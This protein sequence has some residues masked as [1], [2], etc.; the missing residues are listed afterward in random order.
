[1]SGFLR[2]RSNR[3]N[4]PKRERS[5]PAPVP[6][7]HR[8]AA[9]M[10][11]PALLNTDPPAVQRQVLVVK[12]RRRTEAESRHLGRVKALRCVLC[13]ELGMTQQGTTEAHHIR[14]GQ[15]GAQRA[16]DWLA[17]ALCEDCHR[18][19]RGIHGDRSRLMQ[20]K[21]TELDLLAWTLRDL[22]KE[23]A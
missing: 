21:C 15:G 23:G 5:L 3:L 12:G 4:P 6:V 2:S 7:E 18:G 14:A 10:V 11:T 19:P 1:V 16:S 8:R 20:A 22:D 9:V 13:T 17:V